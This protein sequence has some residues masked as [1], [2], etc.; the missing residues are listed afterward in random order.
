MKLRAL[1]PDTDFERIRGW[2]T[3][4]RAHAMWC[5]NRFQYPLDRDEFLSVLAGMTQKT[6]DTPFVAATDDGQA[7]GFFCYSLDRD[8][9]EGKL[10][11]VIVGPEYR[12]KG[13]A[14]E[15]LRLAVSHAFEDADAK[16]VSLVVFAGNPRARKCYE[17]A[18]FTERKT[19]SPAFAYREESWGRCSM[20][21]ERQSGA[22]SG[23][24]GKLI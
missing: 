6:G 13:T 1:D 11:F 24:C 12:G 9:G 3:D 5:A 23:I 2:I 21:M 14:L 16:R 7:A 18:G 20:V 19:D 17:K 10:K 8:S 15:M 22:L 4:E